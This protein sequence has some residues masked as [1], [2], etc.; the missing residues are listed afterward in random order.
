MDIQNIMLIF[1][2]FLSGTENL[3]REIKRELEYYYFL[4]FHLALN[5]FCFA[6]IVKMRRCF[7]EEKK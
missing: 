2:N 6:S 3:M 5:F 4:Y 7:L 1:T